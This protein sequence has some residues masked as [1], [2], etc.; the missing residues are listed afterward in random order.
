VAFDLRNQLMRCCQG[1]LLQDEAFEKA[2]RSVQSQPPLLML[3]APS[4]QGVRTLA[5]RKSSE[6]EEEAEP[7]TSPKGAKTSGRK[8]IKTVAKKPSAKKVKVIEV[9]PDPPILDV[10]PLDEDLDDATALSELTRKVD[11]QKQVLSGLIEAQ[12][13]LEAEDRALAKKYKEAKKFAKLVTVALQ[14]KTQAKDAIKL[15]TA[16]K[17]KFEAEEAERKRLE[18]KEEKKRQAEKAKEERVA[19][20][21]RRLEAKKKAQAEKKKTRR[22]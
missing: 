19:E 18:V 12:K 10:E 11:E 17:A 7:I 13:A 15:A 5:K 16:F 2:K 20:I 14:A 9:I 6:V 21:A 22:A 1:N 3:L 4:D 8:L